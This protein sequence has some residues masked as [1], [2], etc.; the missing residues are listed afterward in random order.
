[1]ICLLAGPLLG[2]GWPAT[3]AVVAMAAF[4]IGL[5]YR[6]AR[7]S[8][9]AADSPLLIATGQFD[10]AEQRIEQVLRRFSILRAVKL[11]SLHHLI[12][13][14]HAQRRW[15]DA[16]MLCRALLRQRL[17]SLESLAHSSRLMLA[18][19]LLEQDDLNG[20][21]EQI[22]GLYHQRLNLT[23]SLNLLL[24]Q[25]DYETR[26]EAWGMMMRGIWSK[27]QLAELMP[28][29]SAAQLQAMLSIAA[30]KTGRRDWADWLRQR[31]H[32]LA[33]IDELVA[34]RPRL[35][36]LLAEQRN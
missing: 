34:R 4:W 23:E 24:I 1:M 2:S 6:S 36:D 10:E 25:L 19:S 28:S 30:E 18:D 12:V 33:D 3:V 26:I 31:A 13:L 29:G 8:N 11:Q 17:G 22:I 5:S 16:A 9:L 14:R 27:V 7:G 32:L 21:Y 15:P 20:A 35:K